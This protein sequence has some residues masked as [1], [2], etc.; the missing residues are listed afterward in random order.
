[1]CYLFWDNSISI[2]ATGTLYVF[3]INIKL[4]QHFL[5]IIRNCDRMRFKEFGLIIK[6]FTYTYIK[7]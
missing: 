6:L 3:W 2:A 1:M 5:M 4:C 7:V